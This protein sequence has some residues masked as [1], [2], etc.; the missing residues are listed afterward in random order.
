MK[1]DVIESTATLMYKIE[2][3]EAELNGTRCEADKYREEARIAK[4]QL[5]LTEEALSKS[6]A[7]CQEQAQHISKLEEEA[8]AFDALKKRSQAAVIGLQEVVRESQ[9]KV[10]QL[11]SRL[12]TVLEKK[13]EDKH[14]SEK[15]AVEATKLINQIARRLGLSESNITQETVLENLMERLDQA[16]VSEMRRSQAEME[17]KKVQQELESMRSSSVEL[18]K[19]HDATFNEK[20]ALNEK[21]GV[22]AAENT[23]LRNQVDL[24]QN[25]LRSK[26]RQILEFKRQIDQLVQENQKQVEDIRKSKFQA[27]VESSQM[28]ALLESLAA[29]LSTVDHPC[30]ATDAG[31]KQAVVELLNRVNTLKEAGNEFQKRVGELKKQFEARIKSDTAI[32]QELLSTRQRTRELETDKSKLE[33]ELL[34]LKILVDNT[35]GTEMRI[36]D[37]LQHA[38]DRLRDFG[39]SPEVRDLISIIQEALSL[40]SPDGQRGCLAETEESHARDERLKWLEQGRSETHPPMDP[41]SSKTA[42]DHQLLNA[43]TNKVYSSD[44]LFNSSDLELIRLFCSSCARSLAVAACYKLSE[45]HD[46]FKEMRT[47][48]KPDDISNRAYEMTLENLQSQLAEAQQRVLE[49]SATLAD[50]EKQK[51]TENEELSKTV[52]RL[53]KARLIQAKKLEHLQ[54]LSEQEASETRR[55]LETLNTSKRLLAETCQKKMQLRDFRDVVG[56]LVNVDTRFEPNAE[57]LILQRIQQLLDVARGLNRMNYGQMFGV[58]PNSWATAAMGCMP[59]VYPSVPALLSTAP[60]GTASTVTFSGT[61]RPRFPRSASAQSTGKVMTPRDN[62]L[63]NR[64]NPSAEAPRIPLTNGVKPDIIRSTESK[65]QARRPVT[66]KTRKPGTTTPKRDERMY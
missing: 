39:P 25:M 35:K 1:S 42:C 59:Q 5:S 23:D 65:I 57:N 33:A 43:L 38:N 46:R 10:V 37:L 50:V 11:E 31:V 62:G 18:T 26:E 63:E 7:K 14:S 52:D 3:L 44:G 53:E 48:S 13:D 64:T 12:R 17:L 32:N 47:M 22:F 56:R 60:V 45:M 24:I 29:T 58:T 41:N 55:K 20:K 6:E 19:R 66:G 16:A 30:V 27:Q 21:F 54:R 28:K 49:L 40:L 2:K 15:H 9:D 4:H 8:K 36:A 34:A 51:A 61:A